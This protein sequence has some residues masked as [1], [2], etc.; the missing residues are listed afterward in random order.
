MGVTV[1]SKRTDWILMRDHYITTNLDVSRGKPYTLKDLSEESR[2]Y[3]KEASAITHAG[4]TKCPILLTHGTRDTIAPLSHSKTMA[5]KL[6]EVKK[7]YEFA[8]IP[9]GDHYYSMLKVGIPLS[10]AFFSEI[11]EHGKTTDLY[12]QFRDNLLKKYGESIKAERE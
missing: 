10:L 5:L 12:K 9:E 3:L 8:E 2:K 7:Y 6:K 11:R 4:N 1:T